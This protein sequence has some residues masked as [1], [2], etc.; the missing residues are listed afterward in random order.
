MPRPSHPSNSIIKCGKKINIFMDK[1]NNKT[2][3]VN[4][5]INLSVDIYSVEK[6]NTFAE[7]NSTVHENISPFG[8]RIII[9]IIGVDKIFNR[10]HSNKVVEFII[11]EIIVGNSMHIRVS[12]TIIGA[13][14]AI[15]VYRCLLFMN[16]GRPH[17]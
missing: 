4:R 10:F 9:N 11:T 12:H 2:K 3:M 1:T 5:L 6:C 17:F 14:F 15:E 7:I 16:K 8:S 13:I